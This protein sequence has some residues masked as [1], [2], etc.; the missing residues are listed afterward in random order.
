[1]AKKNAP[2]LIIEHF[3]DHSNMMFL[4][5]IEYKKT[6]YLGVIDNIR[7]NEIS[8]FVLDTAAAENLDVAWFVT[9]ATKWYYESS[10]Q[11][12]LSF[13][14]AKIGQAER[15]TTILKT[16]KI[17]YVSRLVG[18]IFHFDLDRKPKI[19]RKKVQMIP[20]GVAVTFRKVP[21]ID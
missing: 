16:F 19:K 12:P 3:Q 9:I 8:A 15:V 10:E 1:M 21:H 18:K 13:E 4:A 5:L 17:D 14:F 20:A 7:G 11:Y 2:P 6:T